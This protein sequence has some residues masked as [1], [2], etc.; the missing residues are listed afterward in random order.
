M[1][2][3][4]SVHIYVAGA[5]FDKLSASTTFSEACQTE[6]GGKDPGVVYTFGLLLVGH[7]QHIF[8]SQYVVFCFFIQL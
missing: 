1:N 8:M 2:C 7:S 5:E 3:S 6:S 4:K